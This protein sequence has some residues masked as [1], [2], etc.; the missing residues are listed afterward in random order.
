MELFTLTL[1]HESYNN[2]CHCYSIRQRKQD[3]KK[4]DTS[5]VQRCSGLFH[6]GFCIIVRSF[7]VFWK[8]R[9]EESSHLITVLTQK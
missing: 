5:F 4:I 2:Y 8:V 3:T 9:L 7:C 6:W 1:P